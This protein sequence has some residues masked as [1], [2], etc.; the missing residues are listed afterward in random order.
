MFVV[1]SE[2]REYERPTELRGC[3]DNL[4]DVRAFFKNNKIEHD[5]NGNFN[6][7]INTR[8]RYNGEV[9]HTYEDF[10]IHEIELNKHYETPYDI[11]Y[12]LKL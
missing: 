3:F 5:E 10:F 9:E 6:K 7:I 11:K 4:D 2:V 1:T 12:I 8:K